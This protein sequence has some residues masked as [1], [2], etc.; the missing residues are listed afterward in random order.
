MPASDQVP[1]P[2]LNQSPQ[3]FYGLPPYHGYPF[4]NMQSFPPHY[5]S[6]MQWP[7]SMDEASYGKQFDYHRS[8]RSSSRSKK[9]YPKKKESEYSEEG[10]Q[11]D[12]SDSTYTSD[13]GSDT[14]QENSTKKSLTRNPPEKW[15]FKI[16]TTSLLRGKMGIK[17]EFL[18]NRF[19]MRVMEIPINKSLRKQ[20]NY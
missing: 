18:M 17:V 4:P 9:N 12:S 8:Q 3:Y 16:L 15:L 1:M 13:N 14:Q 10:K 5:P 19:Q 2:F 11:T 20:N 6:N 7:P